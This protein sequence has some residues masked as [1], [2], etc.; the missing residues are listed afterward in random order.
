M[1]EKNFSGK[2]DFSFSSKSL[3]SIGVGGGGV[4]FLRCANRGEQVRAIN[5]LNEMVIKRFFIFGI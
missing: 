2:M 4:Y 3:L 1:F 5:K